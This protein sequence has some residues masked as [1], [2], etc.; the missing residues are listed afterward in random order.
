MSRLRAAQR[1]SGSGRNRRVGRM[2][3]VQGR[4]YGALVC[5]AVLQPKVSSRKSFRSCSQDDK[6]ID[7]YL[8]DQHSPVCCFRMGKRLSSIG[9]VLPYAI[10]I[11]MMRKGAILKL[12]ELTRPYKAVCD[13]CL[14]IYTVYRSEDGSISFQCPVCGTKIRICIGNKYLIYKELRYPRHGKDQIEL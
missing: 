4:L 9:C 7:K 8:L 10:W 6:S 14:N 2:Q 13:N 3:Q 11:W 12:M 5:A 1:R